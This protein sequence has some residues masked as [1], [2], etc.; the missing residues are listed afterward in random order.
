MP[1]MPAPMVLGVTAR[2]ALVRRAL[3]PARPARLVAGRSPWFARWA[4]LLSL[5]GGALAPGACDKVTS[6][7]IALWKTTEKGPGKLAAA[8]NERSLEPKLRAEAAVALVDLGKPE[9][10]EVTLSGLPAS[11]R[12]ELMKTVVP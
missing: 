1:N 2:T 7:N 10:V 3:P 4:M 9:E 12:W 11:E 5:A 6:D 8:L